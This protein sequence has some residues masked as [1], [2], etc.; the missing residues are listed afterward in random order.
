MPNIEP[1]RLITERIRRW[2]V[3]GTVSTLIGGLLFFTID[4]MLSRALQSQLQVAED[5]DFTKMWSHSP[6]P[7]KINIYVFSIMNPD[8]FLGGAKAKLRE[9]GPYTYE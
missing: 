3:I 7:I 6:I 9:Y 2:T 5:N 1:D 8:E 4:S